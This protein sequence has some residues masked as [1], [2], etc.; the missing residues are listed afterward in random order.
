MREVVILGAARTAGGKFGGSLKTLSAGELGAL[1][2]KAV[3]QRSGISADTID[4][5]IFGNA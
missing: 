3:I 1:A 5:T 2:V 4:Q